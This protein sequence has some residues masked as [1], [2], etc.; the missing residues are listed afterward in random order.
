MITNTQAIADI[1]S[2]LSAKIPQG[3]LHEPRKGFGKIRIDFTC[4]ELVRKPPN[5]ICTLAGPVAGR[6]V[7]MIGSTVGEGSCS[8]KQIVNKGVD[9]D[10]V[11]SS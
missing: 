7:R 4:I 1:E 5:D 2:G 10:H 9:R 11:A 3:V 6:A 8:M